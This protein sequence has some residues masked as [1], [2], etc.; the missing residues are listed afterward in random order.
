MTKIEAVE[1]LLGPYNM[2]MG[3]L[4]DY[5]EHSDFI[6]GANWIRLGLIV[7]KEG[8]ECTNFDDVKTLAEQAQALKAASDADAAAKLLAGA[9]N[10]AVLD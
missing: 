3:I 9:D 7:I 2:L 4:H 1:Q 8:I 6:Q 10:G 5:P